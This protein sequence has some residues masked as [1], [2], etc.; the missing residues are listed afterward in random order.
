MANADY[1]QLFFRAE[2]SHFGDLSLFD[3]VT[4][5]WEKALSISSSSTRVVYVELT[6]LTK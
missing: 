1:H 4:I 2:Y 5:L 3:Q 6:L